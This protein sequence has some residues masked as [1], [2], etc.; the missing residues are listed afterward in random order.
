MGYIKAMGKYA[1]FTGRASRREFW[2]FAIVN[3]I[4]WLI[5]SRFYRMFPT[6]VGRNVM[7][8][9]ALMYFA[10]TAVPAVAVIF[11]RWHDLGR[12]GKWIL[13]NL[14]PVAG[15]LATLGFFLCRG[16]AYTNEYGR[17]PYD[18]GLKRKR[19]RRRISA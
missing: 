13:I 11:R 3:T 4:F 5:I 10:V 1:V 18:Q 7:L 15:W 12:T 16:E 14:V 9:V 6:G 17:D 2:G 8:A 19:K